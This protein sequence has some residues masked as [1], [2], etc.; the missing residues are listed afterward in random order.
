MP[1][2]FRQCNPSYQLTVVCLAVGGVCLSAVLAVYLWCKQANEWEQR[3]NLGAVSYQY[4]IE[5]TFSRVLTSLDDLGRFIESSD[6]LSAEEFSYY[7]SPMLHLFWGMAWIVPKAIDSKNISTI[8]NSGNLHDISPGCQPYDV[9]FRYPIKY[10][11][12]REKLN[13]FVGL[14]M[15]CDAERVAA[16]KKATRVKQ[17]TMTKSLPFLAINDSGLVM[18]R[19]IYQ[20]ASRTLVQRGYVTAAVPIKQILMRELAHVDDASQ[21]QISLT[22]RS[23]RPAQDIFSFGNSEQ[24]VTHWS[25]IVNIQFA[26]ETL[27]LQIRPTRS[28]WQQRHD[29]L[30]MLVLLVGV[31]FTALL[32]AWIHSQHSRRRQAELLA[33]ARSDDLID[34]ENRLAALFVHAPIGIIRCDDQGEMVE[35]N[36]TTLRLLGCDSTQLIGRHFISM[37]ST[38]SAQQFLQR[39]QEPV[40]LELELLNSEGE[41]IPILA[42]VIS[43]KLP[44]GKP[45]A[46]AMLE[47]LRSARHSERLKREFIATI[48]H[49]LRTPLAALKGAVDLIRTG[50]LD[51]SPREV[52]LLLAMAASN[53]ETLN[54]LIDDL[55][56]MERLALGKL[57][58]ILTRQALT[59][60][61]VKARHLAAPLMQCKQLTWQESNV[62]LAVFV[63]VDGDRFV[64]VL[65]NLFSNAVKFSPPAGQLLLSVNADL[66]TVSIHIQDQGPG[67]APTFL[68]QLF[69]PFAQADG[70]DS[71]ALGGT[72]LG[73]AISRG[74]IERMGGVLS[75]QS[76]A[77][78]GAEFIIELPRAVSLEGSSD[79]AA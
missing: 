49:E 15:R 1:I 72:G 25:K 17:V 34:R 60:L 3:F 38:W 45:Y 37:L 19:P 76:V 4:N 20:R 23:Q 2:P 46:W 33:I 55:L 68:P 73:L 28:F 51:D 14:D 50:V 64:Q 58:L 32:I 5:S 11:L 66:D 40:W 57:S 31:S 71:R 18:F 30:P 44:N 41:T 54:R 6:D 16:M 24:A 21:Y 22:N 9:N 26:G 47:D 56:D 7:S 10:Y 79:V 53:A 36:P 29:F 59:P 39:W 75:V 35:V 43:L 48:S 13:N 52:A 67:I 77:G 74:L 65:S 61:I 78:L 12:A 27:Q 70:T 62:D 63:S 8:N 69:Q 42:R